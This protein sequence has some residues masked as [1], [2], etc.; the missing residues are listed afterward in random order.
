MSFFKGKKLYLCLLSFE[1]LS[2][3][4]YHRS[5]L[6]LHGFYWCGL[7]SVCA[8][9]YFSHAGRFPFAGKAQIGS[10]LAYFGA[11]LIPLWS[12]NL[13]ASSYAIAFWYPTSHRF[14]CFLPIVILG[15]VNMRLSPASKKA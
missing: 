6:S 14:W 9:L 5:M 2:F 7:I 12:I 8:L 10:K 11:G 13:Q 1:V 3:I 15:L 4:A